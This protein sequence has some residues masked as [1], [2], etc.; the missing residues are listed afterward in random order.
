MRLSNAVWVIVLIAGVLF[1]LR[2]SKNE[3]VEST[4]SGSNFRANV[5]DDTSTTTSLDHS[6]T[7]AEGSGHEAG[8]KRA[9]EHDIDD[10]DDC[11]T[12]GETSNSPS[13]AEG[14]RAYVQENE[15]DATDDSDDIPDGD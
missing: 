9:E 6:P 12:A 10:E 5:P 15:P 3:A 7:F 1:L 11:D 2:Y 13:F 4:L 14:C 8:Y